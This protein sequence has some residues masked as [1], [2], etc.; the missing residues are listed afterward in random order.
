MES[1]SIS[2]LTMTRLSYLGYLLVAGE[3]SATAQGG[4]VAQA[5]EVTEGVSPERMS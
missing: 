1:P 2:H 5:E 4:A 3:K